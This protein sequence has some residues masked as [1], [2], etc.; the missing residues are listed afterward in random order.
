MLLQERKG[1]KVRTVRHGGFGSTFVFGEWVPKGVCFWPCIIVARPCLGG[2][3]WMTAFTRGWIPGRR[4][5][6]N[7]GVYLNIW[8]Y[9]LC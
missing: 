3:D 4:E 5:M 9:E 8:A 1:C 6:G 7:E 2:R